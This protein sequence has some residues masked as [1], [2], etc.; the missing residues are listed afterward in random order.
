[1]VKYW[2]RKRKGLFSGDLGWGWIPISW[3]GW[4]II[5]GFIGAFYW[6]FT[7]TDFNKWIT[8]VVIIIIFAFI[9]D[10]KTEDK[11]MFK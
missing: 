10:L 6:M 8:L 1:M 7:K 4:L 9:A 5:L 2:F 3:E 11:V